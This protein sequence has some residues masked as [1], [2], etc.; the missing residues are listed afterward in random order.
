MSQRTQNRHTA[1]TLVE[2]LVV[3][4]IIA[5]LIGILVPV[6]GKM[7]TSAQRAATASFISNLTGAIERYHTDFGAYP[8]PI[9]NNWVWLPASDPKVMGTPDRRPYLMNDAGAEFARLN[10]LPTMAENLV[11]GL[12][13][14]LSYDSTTDHIQFSMQ[15]LLSG[16]G[17][18]SLGPGNPKQY[19]AYLEPKNLFTTKSPDAQLAVWGKYSDDAASL[20][21]VFGD[22]S[23]PEFVDQFAY[24]MPILYL[25]AKAGAPQIA[26]T[27]SDFSA[28]YNSIITDNKT[29]PNGTFRAG[30]Y[31][32]SQIKAYTGSDGSQRYIGVGKSIKGGDYRPNNTSNPPGPVGS[33][34]I[35]TV[36]VAKVMEKS[37]TANFQY[38][39]DAFAYF[40]NPAIPNA[41]R[42]KDA[43]I[44]ISAGPDR[45]YGT[46]D[47]ITNFGSVAP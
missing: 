6:V 24:P 1:F 2:L 16:R 18:Q 15:R 33:H 44:L 37:D 42:Q 5:I 27:D 9:P 29:A 13:G 32:I 35:R 12:I 17:P 46:A 22:D 30:Q 34:G 7:R 19:P 43:Y 40:S 47:D 41:A 26:P 36:N 23:V 39:Y 28:S 10:P 4:G 20:G 21:G 38:P 45:V 14:G 11:L 8:G 25:R 31:D 3:I